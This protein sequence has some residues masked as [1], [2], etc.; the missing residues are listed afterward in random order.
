MAFEAVLF[1][2]VGSVGPV[3]FVVFE[4]EEGEGVWACVGARECAGEGA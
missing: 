4:A 3:V 2:S 1:P